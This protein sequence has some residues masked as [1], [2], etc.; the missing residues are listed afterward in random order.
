[1]SSKNYWENQYDS[2]FMPWDIETPD[3]NLINSVE[4]F[5]IKA[6]KAL[7]IG[8]G[9]ETNSIWL[10]RS[11]FT[12]L[13]VDVSEFAIAKA[14]EKVLLAD[15]QCEFLA[16]DILTGEMPDGNFEF[17]FDR[18]CFHTFDSPNE[19]RLFAGAVSRNLSK[20]GV[21][22]SLIGSKKGLPRLSAGPPRRSKSDITEAV[23]P[24][25]HIVS[26]T[27]DY[28]ESK[29]ERPAHNWVCMMSKK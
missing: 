22:L 1:M 5:N 4:E 29:L 24:Y 17:I 2:G 27:S 19:R 16:L 14:K 11:G 12:V 13:G 23:E 20:T 15:V 21:W 10:A 6:C 18:G 7:E 8:C 25:F 3:K 9:T 28:F 26:L